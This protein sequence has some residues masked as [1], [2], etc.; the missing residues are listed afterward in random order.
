MERKHQVTPARKFI[1]STL[2]EPWV[3]S[4]KDTLDKF[5]ARMDARRRRAGWPLLRHEP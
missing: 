2:G 5:R 4:A 3:P 1:P